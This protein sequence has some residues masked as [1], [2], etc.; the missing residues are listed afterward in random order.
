MTACFRSLAQ[1]ATLTS[2]MSAVRVGLGNHL[3]HVFICIATRERLGDI[4]G[5]RGR[6]ALGH[7]LPRGS[8]LLLRQGDRDLLP[9]HTSYHT[10]YDL[11]GKLCTVTPCAWKV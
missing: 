9:S 5:H 3:G 10:V 4:P 2:T 8:H 11:P 1:M 7:R 6:R